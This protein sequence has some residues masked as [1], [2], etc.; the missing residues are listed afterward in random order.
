M[1]IADSTAPG[2][3]ER[4]R[5]PSF[6]VIINTVDRAAALA[7]MLRALEQQDYPCFEVIVVV[8]PTQ[9]NTLQLLAGYGDRLRVLRCARANLGES[10]NIGL[11]AAGGEYVAFLDDDAAPCRT[12]LAQL[13]AAFTHPSIAAVGGSVF[14]AYPEGPLLQ[15]RFGVVSELGEQANVRASRTGWPEGKGRL[16]S[17]RPMGTN[18]AFRRAALL[19]VGG[20]DTHYAWVYDDADVAWRLALGGYSVH[21]LAAAAVYHI[22]ASSR[23]RVVRTLAGRWY[24]GTQ[25]AA[26]FAVQNG[27][28][29][30]QPPGA[31]LVHVLQLV[32]GVWLLSGE[33]HRDG[34]IDGRQMWAR[35][36]QGTLAAGRGALAG[37]GRRRLLPQRE[38]AA[39]A[40]RAAMAVQ[41]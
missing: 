29:A 21:G 30:G 1:S 11:L 15:H 23:N 13:A 8:G 36:W 34:K 2:C 6:S 5:W 31:I 17:E 41:T 22:P 12:W 4:E 38:A 10:R 32:H 16:W 25:A 33:L 40:E 39:A 3:I 27:R 7:T 9:D 24:V 37:L 35:R 20:F 18:M 19:A 28:A 26:Y 14:M